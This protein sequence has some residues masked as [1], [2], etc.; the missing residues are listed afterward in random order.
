M[1]NRLSI[2]PLKPPGG[3]AIFVAGMGLS[4]D[5]YGIMQNR[6]GEN[7]LRSGIYR[8]A[9]V[10]GLICMLTSCASSPHIIE[11]R[12]GRELIAINE[13]V[14]Q[15]KTGYFRYVDRNGRDAMVRAKDVVHIVELDD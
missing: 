11:L 9:A 13:P 6:C 7:N 1:R 2:S 4:H 5:S 3:Q 8:A 12:G 14:Y 10:A 15:S